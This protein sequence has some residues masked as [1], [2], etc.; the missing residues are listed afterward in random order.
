M[1]ENEDSNSTRII[2]VN[3]GQIIQNYNQ[4]N[5]WYNLIIF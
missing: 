3:Q 1:Q 2:M 4:W 5:N